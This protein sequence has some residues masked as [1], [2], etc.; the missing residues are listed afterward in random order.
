MEA[1]RRAVWC[2]AQRTKRMKASSRRFKS[3]GQEKVD[4]Q[5]WIQ[6]SILRKERS[7]DNFVNAKG[8][9]SWHPLVVHLCHPRA[10]TLAWATFWEL[11]SRLLLCKGA[12]ASTLWPYSPR[13]Q[14]VFQSR[15][16]IVIIK[17]CEP[18]KLHDLITFSSFSKQKKISIASHFQRNF[19]T[20]KIRINC[21]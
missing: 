9:S 16:I 5:M 1:R 18:A 8:N 2:K 17:A 7:L 3:Y 10:K 15:W 20:K 6:I 21:I 13:L 11:S 4:Y 12:A 14:R 19:D